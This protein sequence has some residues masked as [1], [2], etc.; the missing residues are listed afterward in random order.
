MHLSFAKL[1]HFTSSD[2]YFGYSN[3]TKF[4]IEE[5][6]ELENAP[7]KTAYATTNQWIKFQFKKKKIIQP[8]QKKRSTYKNVQPTIQIQPIKNIQ[9]IKTY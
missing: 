7:A 8:N 5:S 6:T 1:N 3:V 4:N 9:P 2:I